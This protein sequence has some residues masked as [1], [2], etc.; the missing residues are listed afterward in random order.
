MEK[1]ALDHLKNQNKKAL[2]Y[3]GDPHSKQKKN[4]KEISFYFQKSKEEKV[5]KDVSIQIHPLFCFYCEKNIFKNDPTKRKSKRRIRI[6]KKTNVCELAE[7]GW[8]V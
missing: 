5:Q 3:E 1:C 8:R 7:V 6:R 2:N 4:A